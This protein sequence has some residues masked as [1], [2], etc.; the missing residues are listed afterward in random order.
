M[1]NGYIL[2]KIA[3]RKRRP[4]LGFR[5]ELAKMLIAGYNG[6]KQPSDSGKPAITT[7]T[8]KENLREHFL[9][10]LEGQIKACAMCT[11]VGRKRPQGHTFKTLYACEQCG[12][13]LCKQMQGEQPVLDYR[14]TLTNDM[15]KATRLPLPTGNT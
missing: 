6:Y 3:G 9:G 13:P 10:K 5:C 11:K 12:I 14:A 8:S 2:E 7:V 1:V 4:Q 15:V